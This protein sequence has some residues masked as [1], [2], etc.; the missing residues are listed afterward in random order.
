MLLRFL[1]HILILNLSCERSLL[2]PYPEDTILILYQFLSV[3]LYHFTSVANKI[4]YCNP[5]FNEYRFYLKKNFKPQPRY[6]QI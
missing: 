3:A 4:Y 1:A 5:S 2:P 6:K